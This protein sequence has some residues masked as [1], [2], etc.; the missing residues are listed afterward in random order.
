MEKQ[1]EEIREQQKA[2]WNK[3]SPGW[4]KWDDLMMDFLQPMGDEIIKLLRLKDKISQI[5]I[6]FNKMFITI[7]IMIISTC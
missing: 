7:T 1:L 6:I 4:K 2:S 5:R 3:F